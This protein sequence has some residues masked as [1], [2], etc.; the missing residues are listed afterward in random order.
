MTGNENTDQAPAAYYRIALPPA[1]KP[2]IA[3]SGDPIRFRRG[4]YI[5]VR[6][7]SM[8]SSLPVINDASSEARNSTP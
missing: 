1:V 8:T 3:P 5:A 6:P 7:P 4:G 2:A